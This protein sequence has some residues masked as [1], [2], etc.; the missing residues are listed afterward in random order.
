M[1]DAYLAQSIDSTEVDVTIDDPDYFKRA[2]NYDVYVN[3][4]LSNPSQAEI[5]AFSKLNIAIDGFYN[6]GACLVPEEDDSACPDCSGHGSCSSSSDTI[7][8]CDSGYA[9]KD[10]SLSLELFQH[11]QDIEGSLVDSYL[12]NFDEELSCAVGLSTEIATTLNTLGKSEF[13]SDKTMGTL[14]KLVGKFMECESLD[15]PFWVDVEAA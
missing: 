4:L 14:S 9:L 8:V 15:G 1:T 6:L 2:E 11:F 7:C 10:C 5:E 12:E 3:R 13:R